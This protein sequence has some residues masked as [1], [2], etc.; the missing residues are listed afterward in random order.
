MNSLSVDFRW[1]GVFFPGKQMCY[2]FFFKTFY[3]K[4]SILWGD[5]IIYTHAL[6]Y[7]DI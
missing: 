3:I 2:F 7:M 4:E 5:T 6:I 1:F